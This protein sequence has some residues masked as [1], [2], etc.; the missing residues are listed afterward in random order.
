MPG[1]KGKRKLSAILYADVKGYS[2]LMGE[3]EAYT[4]EM[5][6]QYRKIFHDLIEAYGGR[7]VNSPG[8]SILSEFPSA[9]DAVRCASSFQMRIKEENSTI[10]K[11]LR[12]V[13]RIGITIGDIIQRGNEI[14]G[15][16]VN[17]AARV[18]SLSRPGGICITR[19][20]FDQVKKQ[21]S[22]FEFKYLGEKQVKNISEPVRV[23]HVLSKKESN[24]QVPDEPS[25]VPVEKDSLLSIAVF[26]F[27]NFSGSREHDYF[28]TGF[29]EDLVID[30]SHFKNLTVISSY[31]ARKI[32]GAGKD[33]LSVSR[34]LGIHY[35][36]KGTLSLR[37]SKIR[38]N[39]QLFETDGGVIVWAERYDSSAE[40]IFKIQDDIIQQVS[41][42]ISRQIDRTLLAASRNKPVTRLDVYD[43]WLQG[44][45]HLRRGTL[46]AD[47]KARQ[48]FKKALVIDPNYSRAY[49][50]LS[51]SYFNEWSCQVWGKWDETIKNAYRFAVK[52][53]RLDNTDH[54]TQMVIGRTMLY[55]RK[56][57]LAEQHIDNSLALNANDADNLVQI[58]SCKSYLGKPEQGETLFLRSLKLN[59]YRNIW[60]YTYGSVS[61]LI[62]QQYEKAIETAL[63]GPLTDEWIDL[64][65]FLAAAYAYLGNSKK[66]AHYLDVFLTTFKRDINAGK[67]FGPDEVF[68][69]VEIAN[70]FKYKSHLNILT[71]GLMLAGLEKRAGRPVK[72]I[73]GGNAFSGPHNS[74]ED[75]TISHQGG[76]KAVNCFKKQGRIWQMDFNGKRIQLPELK[77][78]I[79][80]T[81]L[82]AAQ[83]HEI[84]CIELMG[85][86]GSMDKPDAV[87]DAKAKNAY[88]SKIKDLKEEIELAEK[89]ND[90][91]RAGITR[92]KLEK[93]TAFLAES[94]GFGK[95]I[96]PL[97]SPAEKARAAVTLRIRNAIKKIKSLHPALG[98]HF[99]NS[100]RTGTFCSYV[101]EKET[102]WHL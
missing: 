21:L 13:F 65:A 89:N 4:L 74:D 51:L 79:D 76:K 50:G 31:T 70:P 101:P 53:A 32:A 61:Y 96:R 17:I 67:P 63:K 30:L 97:K 20:V 40:T 45:D 75:E 42:T 54:L 9:V 24:A 27:E 34:E 48:I 6:I 82:L 95:R 16:G 23:Y 18:E 1:I 39:T 73:T 35:I 25:A 77:G 83:G 86:T 8:D 22:Y 71:K 88:E 33:E 64:P 58:S 11:N 5:L 12:M 3:N 41:G 47:E 57:D 7:L 44:M 98:R 69:W 90:I 28:T 2:R 15:D 19:Y 72:R 92:E 100:I 29:V 59:P 46:A 62:Q 10:P 91:E 56:F 38:I 14:Y 26:P 94:Y 60:Y 87:M 78:F 66:A 93:I 52:A 84:H 37:G 85:S 80:I 102:A 68:Q 81:S 99:E 55:Y 49:T 36:L 43:L